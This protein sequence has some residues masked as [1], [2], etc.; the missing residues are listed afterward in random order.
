MTPCERVDELWKKTLSQLVDFRVCIIL[1]VI[2]VVDILRAFLVFNIVEIVI[3]SILALLMATCAYG[4]HKLSRKYLQE[5]D[6]I[7]K[8]AKELEAVNNAI[9]PK[10][11]ALI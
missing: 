4:S 7:L 10:Q 3:W 6:A 9:D 8:E 1:A 2:F 5:K 11:D